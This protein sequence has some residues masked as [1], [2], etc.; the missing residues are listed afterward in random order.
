[1]REFIGG[2]D[3]PLAGVLAAAGIQQQQALTSAQQHGGGFTQVDKV[4]L[5][6]SAPA[7]VFDAVDGAQVQ[8]RRQG[9]RAFHAVQ[10]GQPG[11]I[12]I[13]S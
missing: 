3:A 4:A 1:L 12:P 6:G 7:E 2:I 9:E 13:I 8:Q 10:P 11:E 5:Q